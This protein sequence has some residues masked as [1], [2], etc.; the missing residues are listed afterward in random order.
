MSIMKNE[1][2]IYDKN[3]ETLQ[4][5]REFFR[6]K[7]EYSAIFI[8]DKHSLFN[9]LTRKTPAALIVGS[10]AELG[11]IRH[12]NTGCPVIA[13]LSGDISKGIRSVMK[14]NIECYLISPFHREDFEYKLKTAIGKKAFLKTSTE[15]KRP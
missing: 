4:F 1:I 14:R 5:L 2:L 3:K 7:N 6:E 11:K 8:K 15:R 9:R 10:P 13:M 12:S